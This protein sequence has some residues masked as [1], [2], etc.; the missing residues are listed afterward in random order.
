MRR[1]SF[2]P[3]CVGA[4]LVLAVA[5]LAAA[6]LPPR[7]PVVAEYFSQAHA[8]HHAPEVR[9]ARRSRPGEPRPRPRCRRR[10][11]PQAA[12]GLAGA[13]RR[14]RELR[15]RPAAG[16]DRHARGQPRGPGG[17]A[18]PGARRVHRA[19]PAHPAVAQPVGHRRGH[20]GRP[21]GGSGGDVVPDRA[22]GGAAPPERMAGH[23][24][25]RQPGRLVRQLR[26]GAGRSGGAGHDD[27]GLAA[28]HRVRAV[29]AGWRPRR[30]TS[31][32]GN[33]CSS[34]SGPS[35]R[36]C[37]STRPTG[38]TTRTPG[39]WIWSTRR[40]W[41][42]T[43]SCAPSAA[44]RTCPRWSGAGASC[45]RRSLR[46]RAGRK[47]PFLFTEVGYRSRQG[48]TASPWDE[49]G[50]GAPDL[51]EQRRAFAAFR[52]VWAPA[53]TTIAGTGAGSPLGEPAPTGFAGLYVWNWY[54]FGGPG[55]VS[56]TPR[57]KPAAAEVKALLEGL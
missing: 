30:A 16:R 25:A 5:V 42:P 37:W 41:S 52:N 34:A 26:R 27:R 47:Q 45:A 32:A 23:P 53:P 56:Y 19:V 6:G 10:R 17:A 13:V 20:P 55:T 50:G 14:G 57:G 38:T 18:L 51:D 8:R 35:T 28:G 15:L 31:T 21:P 2:A 9:A 12:G 22:P 48:A 54:G 33:A 29:V 40:G 44:R 3:L 11:S 24:R 7:R 39:C 1:R 46:W 36:A 43:S 4:L 49:G